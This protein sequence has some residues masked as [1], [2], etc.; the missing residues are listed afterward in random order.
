MHI[1][2]QLW[3]KNTWSWPLPRPEKPTIAARGDNVVAASHPTHGKT[4]LYCMPS[5]PPIGPNDPEVIEQGDEDDSVYPKLLFTENETNFQR[6]YGGKNEN[7]YAK[8]AFHDHIIRWHRPSMS[9]QMFGRIHSQNRYGSD[10]EEQGPKTPIPDS[11]QAP[12]TYFSFTSPDR[13]TS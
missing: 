10:E 8:D 13:K 7:V 4:N 2:P 3:F 6:L 12:V 9:D 1:I 11:S 5:P